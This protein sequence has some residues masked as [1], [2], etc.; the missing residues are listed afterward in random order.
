[1]FDLPKEGIVW[2]DAFLGSSLRIEGWLIL[3]SAG[4]GHWPAC[5]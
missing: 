5:E 2:M 4:D 3:F 1:L